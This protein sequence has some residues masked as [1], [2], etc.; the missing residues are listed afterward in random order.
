MTKD[1]EQLWRAEQYQRLAALNYE[2]AV[3]SDRDADRLIYQRM[4]A[5]YSRFSRR[6]MGIEQ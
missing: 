5:T 6:L 1:E 3:E 2:K 4:G